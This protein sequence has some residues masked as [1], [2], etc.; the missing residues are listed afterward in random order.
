MDVYEQYLEKKWN[1][2]LYTYSN[3][4]NASENACYDIMRNNYTQ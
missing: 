1:K 2:V 3:I 4:L